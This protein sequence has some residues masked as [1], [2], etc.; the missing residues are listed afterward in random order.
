MSWISNGCT[1][2]IFDDE[3][4]SDSFSALLALVLH[5]ARCACACCPAKDTFGPSVYSMWKHFKLFERLKLCTAVPVLEWPLNADGEDG[6]RFRGIS[7]HGSQTL[8][9]TLFITMT[10]CRSMTFIPKYS[11]CLT[12]K[13]EFSNLI[14]FCIFASFCHG[15]V[16]GRLDW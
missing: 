8:E 5:L 12:L 6:V 4:K 1:E 10:Y 2:S 14:V 3:P 13:L 9:E 11:E 7:S 15:A 16:R